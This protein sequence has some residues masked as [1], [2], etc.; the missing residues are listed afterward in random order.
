MS[1]KQ[2]L[3]VSALCGLAIA[4]SPEGT[5][6]DTAQTIVTTADSKPA[7]EYTQ[8]VNQSYYDQLPFDDVRDFENAQRGFLASEE[9]VHIEN[10]NGQPVWSL[11][12]YSTYIGQDS[13]APDTVNPSLWRNA[14]LGMLHGLFQVDENIYQ[15]RGYDLTNITFVKGDTGWIVFDPLLSE[16]TATRA[17]EF[18]TAQLG[19]YPIKAVVYSHSH[20]DHYGGVRGLFKNG[21]YDDVAIIAPEHFADHAVS[22]NV[23]AGN[24]MGRRAILMYGAMLPRNERGGVNGGLGMTVSTGNVGLIEPTQEII[25]SGE[26][27]TID[28][29]EMVF[30]LTP[31][32]EAPAEMNTYFPQWKALWMA[33]NA[34]NTLHNVLTL[35]G[36][37]VRDPLIW[38]RYLNE[39]IALWGDE[40]EVKFQSHHWPVWGNEEIVPYLEKQRDIYKFIHDQ[41]VRLMN[42][43]FTGEEISEMLRL[44]EELENNWATRGYYGTL[45]HNSRAVYQRY[46]GWYT[47]N[48]SDLNNY[49]PVEAAQ[50]YI[51]FM[52]GEQAT[53][54]KT[55]QSFNA[56]DYRWVAEVGKHLV[57]NNPDNQDAKN[58]LADAYEQLG[59]QAE[60]G[61]W[62]SV[63]LQGA[64]ELRNGVP[65]SGGTKTDGPDVI[66]AMTPEMVFDYLAI[67][68]NYEKAEGADFSIQVDFT[69]LGESHELVVKNAVLNHSQHVTGN[70]DVKLKMSMATMNRIQ[71]GETTLRDA[72]NDGSVELEG[73]AA[74]VEN[75]FAM[76]DE[77]SFWFNIVTP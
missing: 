62:R 63:Y 32:T 2:T 31:G 77:F 76:L 64:F 66:R 45:R 51:A 41:S 11:N 35:R 18:L 17:F 14:Q 60:S 53:M 65:T 43:G 19:E 71:L 74:I 27:V 34:T 7:T 25:E 28:G 38:A 24:A 26:V 16:E 9:S 6:N 42:H 39:T 54:E 4:C 33:E 55:L 44:P 12:E 68:L 10:A 57:F 8:Q 47:G 59:Y 67:R 56:G 30:Q 23:I 69:D 29:V 72:V 3:L 22:E 46:M 50:R 52:G 20:A 70:S 13:A 73:D 48:P 21:S 58:L 61:P 15:I 36:A 40:V 75:F 1:V 49:P 5:P 37:L